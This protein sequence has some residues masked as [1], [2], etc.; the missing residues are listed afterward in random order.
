M[1]LAIVVLLIFLLLLALLIYLSVRLVTNIN[2]IDREYQIIGWR[3]KFF[4]NEWMNAIK[5]LQSIELH[6]QLNRCA[7]L[8][9]NRILDRVDQYF[10]KNPIIYCS[11][12]D[13]RVSEL[14]QT[15]KKGGVIEKD[16][17]LISFLNLFGLSHLYDNLQS[18]N[19]GSGKFYLWDEP[20]GLDKYKKKEGLIEDIN[21]FWQFL[22]TRICND[23][24]RVNPDKVKAFLIHF[25]N[26]MCP[27]P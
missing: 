3:S 13:K 7:S 24:D 19:V 1:I 22:R 12:L 23:D 2:N 8:D 15:F 10:K 21:N 9:K 17:N 5:K 18:N 25:M 16:E 4:D 14:L 6:Y 20:V 11:A 26:G 27:F